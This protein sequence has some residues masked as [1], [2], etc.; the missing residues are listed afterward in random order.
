MNPRLRWAYAAPL[1]AALVVFADLALGT[2]G[3]RFLRS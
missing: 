2:S 1:V 3:E